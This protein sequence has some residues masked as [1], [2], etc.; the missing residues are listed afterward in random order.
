MK[1]LTTEEMSSCKGGLL[2][3]NFSTVVPVGNIAISLP[4]ALNVLGEQTVV[5]DTLALASQEVGIE[6]VA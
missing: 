1:D 4:I 3:T 6:Q 2:D 5:Q